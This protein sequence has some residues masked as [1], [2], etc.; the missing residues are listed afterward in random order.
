MP[1]ELANE[2]AAKERLRKLLLLLIKHA[3]PS[4]AKNPWLL[5]SY[6][7]AIAHYPGFQVTSRM[8]KSGPTI[9]WTIV[10][11]EQLIRDIKQIMGERK[12]GVADAC[13]IAVQRFPPRYNAKV[14][15]T[16]RAGKVLEA[17]YREALKAVRAY[18]QR[19]LDLGLSTKSMLPSFR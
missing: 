6:E 7:L 9:K 11:Q 19:L 4:D 10:Q 15:E 14:L 18:H 1:L 12:R 17:R 2:I 5:L 3:I 8:P 16:K 13:R